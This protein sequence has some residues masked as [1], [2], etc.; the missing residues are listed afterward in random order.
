[1]NLIFINPWGS[2]ADIGVEIGRSVDIIVPLSP[3]LRKLCSKFA[4]S[5]R[6][7]SVN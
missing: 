6:D 2:S 1:M 5:V 7:R 4:D 3:T